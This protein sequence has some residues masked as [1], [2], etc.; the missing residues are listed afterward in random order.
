MQKRLSIHPGAAINPHTSLPQPLVSTNE[1]L[2]MLD[3][4]WANG[5]WV[6][7]ELLRW[8]DV[9][10]RRP[11]KLDNNSTSHPVIDLSICPSTTCW[12][13]RRSA[14]TSALRPNPKY[15]YT[16]KENRSTKDPSVFRTQWCREAMHFFA[17]PLAVKAKN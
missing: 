16:R 10:N 7:A 14:T 2:A 1:E 17:P 8:A 3:P 9:P 5:R 15:V 6:W 4:L 12:D 13:L 11:T